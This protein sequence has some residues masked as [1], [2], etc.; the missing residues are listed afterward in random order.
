MPGL[1]LVFACVQALLMSF[2]IKSC[3]QSQ[4]LRP[5]TMKHFF[6]RFNVL[7]SLHGGFGFFSGHLPEPAHLTVPHWKSLLLCAN[8]TSWQKAS[9]LS[10]GTNDLKRLI[11][12][13]CNIPHP[14]FLFL[15]ATAHEALLLVPC[16]PYPTIPHHSSKEDIP[17]LYYFMPGMGFAPFLP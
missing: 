13:L 14:C 9:C 2:W 16:R 6:S 17:G 10:M 1:Q 15:P 5:R 11:P 12:M 7:G 8:L 4:L 3:F